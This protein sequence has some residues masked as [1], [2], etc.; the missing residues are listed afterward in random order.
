MNPT[1]WLQFQVDNYKKFLSL[2]PMKKETRESHEAGFCDGARTG[3][4]I[5]DLL[6]NAMTRI[7]PSQHEEGCPQFDYDPDHLP[8]NCWMGRARVVLSGKD[9]GL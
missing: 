8:C 9:G 2:L 7:G 5:I 1:A 4:S 6:D 3:A